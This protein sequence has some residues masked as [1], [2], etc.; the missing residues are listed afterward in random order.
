MANYLEQSEVRNAPCKL[1]SSLENFLESFILYE[2]FS[3]MVKL[4]GYG[5]AA[6]LW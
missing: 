5:E 1:T 4:T 3:V 6:G 2:L